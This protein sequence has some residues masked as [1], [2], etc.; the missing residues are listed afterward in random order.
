MGI[1]DTKQEGINDIDFPLFIGAYTLDKKII[2]SKVVAN[3]KARRSI[4]KALVE[5]VKLAKE[6]G[7][8][9]ITNIGFQ[10]NL[11]SGSNI[12]FVAYGDMVKFG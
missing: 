4:A 5:L 6:S 3:N 9:A 7:Y 2:E 10:D 12:G 1:F 11:Y 8:D